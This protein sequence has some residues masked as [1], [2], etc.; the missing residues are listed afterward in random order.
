VKRIGVGT[1]VLLAAEFFLQNVLDFVY[2]ILIVLKTPII[3]S[4]PT[5]GDFIIRTL[6]GANVVKVAL[7]DLLELIYLYA[8]LHIQLCL[9]AK[10]FRDLVD[11]IALFDE[12]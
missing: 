9:L 7:Y 3:T 10:G 2:L 12:C 8:N 1:V 4:P 11:L 6:Q 5:G